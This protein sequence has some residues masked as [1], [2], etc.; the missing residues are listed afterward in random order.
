MRDQ[1]QTKLGWM[2]EDNQSIIN[3]RNDIAAATAEA[4]RSKQRQRSVNLE[5]LASFSKG[6]TDLLLDRKKEKDKRD[7]E[8]GYYEYW[9]GNGDPK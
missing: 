5:E 6:V 7:D 8:E 4:N 1:L 3:N 2:R 9:A